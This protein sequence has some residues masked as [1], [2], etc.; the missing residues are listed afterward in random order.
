VRETELAAAGRA[1]T[2]GSALGGN[3]GGHQLQRT[4]SGARGAGSR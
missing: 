4:G 2:A 3:V 1:A